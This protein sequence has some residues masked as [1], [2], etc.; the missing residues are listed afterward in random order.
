ME[1]PIEFKTWA[2]IEVMGHN[3]YAGY[4]TVENI[5]GV[6]M[7]RVDVPTTECRAGFTKY[8]APSALYGITP[9]SEE[10]VRLRVASKG[11]TPFD[12]WDMAQVV[13]DSL[14]KAGRLLPP[15]GFQTE[16]QRRLRDL[17]RVSVDAGEEEV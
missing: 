4:V 17:N 3:E 6:P 8:L 5:A 14:Q 15:A 1:N 7:L 10:T 11:Y 16:E 9:C 13:M 2:I 12:T